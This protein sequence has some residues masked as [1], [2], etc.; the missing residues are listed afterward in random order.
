MSDY[1]NLL[2]LFQQLEPLQ[3]ETE[4]VAKGLDAAA[5]NETRNATHHLLIALCESSKCD[6]EIKKAVNHTKRAIYDCHEAMLLRE[7]DKF[8]VFKEDYKNIV[9]TDV[10]ADYVIR[11]QQAEAAKDKITAIRQLDVK[12]AGDDDKKYSP[13]RNKLYDD[14]APFLNEI[15][16][17]NKHFE[18]AR[19]ELNKIIR[20]EFKE[21]RK[22]IWKV[23]GFLVATA[24]G[25]LAWLLP[26]SP[27]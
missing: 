6:D 1:K 14:I 12:H 21:G 10:I 2:K 7:L 16:Q 15:K 27:T 22:A 8:K 3:K 23:V 24:V 4:Q 19:P 17:N 26:N 11:C 5:L 9:I 18:Q 13:D 25:L 20:R